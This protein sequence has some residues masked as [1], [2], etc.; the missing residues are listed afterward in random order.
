MP[1]GGT[2]WRGHNEGV[3]LPLPSAA[4]DR[5]AALMA[6]LTAEGRRFVAKTR[7]EA[8]EEYKDNRAYFRGGHRYTYERVYEF[9]SLV[10]NRYLS[11]LRNDGTFTISGVPAGATREISSTTS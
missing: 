6:D 2:I 1:G 8:E 5:L 9:R 10:E 4:A 11:I 7:A 3:T